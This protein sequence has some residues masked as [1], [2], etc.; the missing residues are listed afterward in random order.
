MAEGSPAASDL[1]HTYPREANPA[2][3]PWMEEN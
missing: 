1:S 2:I 3:L